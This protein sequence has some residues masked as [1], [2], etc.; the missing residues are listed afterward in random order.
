MRTSKLVRLAEDCG[1][2]VDE[3]IDRYAIDSVVP[4]ICRHEH[5]DYCAEYEPDQRAGWCEEC[6]T[7]SVVSG[8]VLAGLI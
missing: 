4:G 2:S 1:F 7:G 8:L 5:C 3:F 6:S